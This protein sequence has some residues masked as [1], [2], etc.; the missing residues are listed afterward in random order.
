[1]VP[2]ETTVEPMTQSTETAAPEAN[3]TT[4][5]TKSTQTK[6]SNGIDIR[7]QDETP[8]SPSAKKVP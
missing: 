2:Y 6:I 5:E 7:D 3:E 8:L 1:M 4:V